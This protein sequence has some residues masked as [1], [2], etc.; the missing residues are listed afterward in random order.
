MRP[1]LKKRNPAVNGL[2]VLALAAVLQA[3]TSSP[4]QTRQMLARAAEYESLRRYDLAAE[5]YVRLTEATPAD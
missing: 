1:C 5:I 3:Q 2:L 4:Q